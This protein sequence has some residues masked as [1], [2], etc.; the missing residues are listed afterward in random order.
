[1]IG[2]IVARDGVVVCP[3]TAVPRVAAGAIEV[4]FRGR[5]DVRDRLL[6]RGNGVC[7]GVVLGGGRSGNV[8]KDAQALERLG[9]GVGVNTGAD[10]AAAA[11]VSVDV[12]VACISSGAIPAGAGAARGEGI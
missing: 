4:R 1:M 3:A 9:V 2:G 5:D 7:M 10:A 11:G 8:F 6:Y 12:G